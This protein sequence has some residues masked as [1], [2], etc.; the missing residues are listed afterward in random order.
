MSDYFVF[1]IDGTLADCGHRIK[2]LQQK[3]KNWDAF[4]SHEEMMQDAVIK[5]T[6]RIFQLIRQDIESDI[7]FVTGRPERTR[8]TT[9]QWIQHNLDFWWN[10]HAE[11]EVLY[12]RAD[13][14]RRDDD[15]V[16]TEIAKKIGPE[17][18][19]CVF[20]DRA[21]VVKAWRS[22]GI[23]VCQVAEGDY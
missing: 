8:F 17:N 22:L 19:I 11:P 5:S 13:G 18:I 16:K 9:K 7:I 3:P 21:R 1:D 6:A 20:D 15:I 2:Y 10:D 14:D 23:R 4:F 12:M